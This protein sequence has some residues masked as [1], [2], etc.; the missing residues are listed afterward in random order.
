MMLEN[1]RALLVLMLTVFFLSA[2]SVTTKPVGEGNR[3]SE[4]HAV[5]NGGTGGR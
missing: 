4:K 5:T 2:C 3:L 1:P